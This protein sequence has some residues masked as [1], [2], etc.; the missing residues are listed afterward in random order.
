MRQNIVK[1]TVKAHV[2]HGKAAFTHEEAGAVN[3]IGQHTKQG[4]VN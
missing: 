4:I 1:S 3:S 2:A